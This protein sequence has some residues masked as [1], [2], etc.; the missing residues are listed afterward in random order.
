MQIGNQTGAL[1]AF[2][3]MRDAAEDAS[4]KQLEIKAYQ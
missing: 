4:L 1:K 2:Q 3:K